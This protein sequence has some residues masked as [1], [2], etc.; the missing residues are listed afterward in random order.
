MRP[1]PYVACRHHLFSNITSY[2]TI[3]LPHGD[4]LDYLR[5]MSETCSLDVADEGPQ[6]RV[7]VSELLN[8]T[9]Q[10]VHKVELIA[11]EKMK[12]ALRGE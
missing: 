5:T 6:N 8:V 7:R 11:L 2:G 1:C 4:N 12:A 10:A 3:N 9:A